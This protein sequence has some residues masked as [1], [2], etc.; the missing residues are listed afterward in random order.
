MLAAT[1]LAGCVHPEVDPVPLEAS[2]PFLCDGVPEEG[3][4]LMTGHDD[5]VVLDRA[6]ALPNL[7]GG[8]RCAVGPPG[9]KTALSV[10]WES[11]EGMG[12][13]FPEAYLDRMAEEQNAREIVADADGGGFVVGPDERPH[14]R[15]VCENSTMVTVT[16]Y[17]GLTARDG[18][19]DVSRY[20]TS[21]LPW[22]CGDAEPPKRTT[23]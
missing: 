18:F 1:G 3:A 12:V 14:G 23:G 5:L 7:A 19:E 21:L 16:L 4:S 22:T 13:G 10:L 8:V 11:I 6:G 17:E 15:W 2:A 20:V 9:G